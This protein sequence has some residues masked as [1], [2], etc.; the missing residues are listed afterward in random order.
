MYLLDAKTA[1]LFT[2]EKKRGFF[3]EIAEKIKEATR[4]V[5]QQIRFKILH[6]IVH[7]LT[8]SSCEAIL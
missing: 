5:A 1:K 7:S 2:A 4:Q 8:N 3:G 6:S